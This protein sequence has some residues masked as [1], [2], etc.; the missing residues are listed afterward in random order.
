M[1]ILPAVIIPPDYVKSSS[2]DS[3]WAV[4]QS[5]N[6][7]KM[8][9][10]PSDADSTLQLVEIGVD[11]YSYV[12]GSKSTPPLNAARFTQIKNDL[13]SMK[14]E[15]FKT[16]T[17]IRIIAQTISI[18][19]SYTSLYNLLASNPISPIL[20]Y[21]KELAPV[22]SFVLNGEGL[23]SDIETWK[24][25]QGT[26]QETKS[27]IKMM[28]S[29]ASI[30]LYA[31]Q[32]IAFLSMTKVHIALQVSLSTILYGASIY[33]IILKEN[34]GTSSIREKVETPPKLSMMV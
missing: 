1:T 8:M 22:A 17:A 2:P 30:L 5:R 33:D 13:M 11:T 10:A 3:T 7:V 14:I 16:V 26:D 18:I 12:E 24:K 28:G 32:V 27:F 21:D 20:P 34:D 31:A 19:Q 15:G 23:L 9:G 6:A 25:A 4:G 29:T